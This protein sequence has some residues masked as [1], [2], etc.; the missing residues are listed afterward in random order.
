VRPPPNAISGR[1]GVRDLPGYALGGGG[2]GDSTR[3]RDNI[4]TSTGS[5]LCRDQRLRALSTT[6][7]AVPPEQVLMAGQQSDGA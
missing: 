2:S 5:S 6:W 7:I 1:A 3:E 4:V